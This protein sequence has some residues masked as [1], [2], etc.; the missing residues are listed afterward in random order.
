[1]QTMID[2]SEATQKAVDM[3]MATLAEFAKKNK[4][5]LA[6][7]KISDRQSAGHIPDGSW[8]NGGVGRSL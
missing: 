3:L 6:E 4:K 1:M 2:A 8:K 7:L 5:L